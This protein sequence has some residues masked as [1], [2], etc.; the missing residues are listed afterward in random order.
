MNPDIDQTCRFCSEQKETFIHFFTDCPALWQ[1]REA[2]EHAQP[3]GI[4]EFVS[5]NQLLQFSFQPKINSALENPQE[6]EDVWRAMEVVSGTDEESASDQPMEGDS[7][8]SISDASEAAA[9]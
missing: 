3:G 1:A 5:P 6:V 2:T 4:L 7:D 8:M 9:P